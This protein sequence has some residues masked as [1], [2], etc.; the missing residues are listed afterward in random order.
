M[1]H[2]NAS[3]VSLQASSVAPVSFLSVRA[4]PD[5]ARRVRL[6]PPRPRCAALCC[7][8]RQI[9]VPPGGAAAAAGYRRITLAAVDG[10]RVDGRQP[11]A[12]VLAEAG[13]PQQTMVKIIN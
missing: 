7:A 9:R 2:R 4:V 8:G 11:E 3:R 10:V 13:R 6:P 12:R 5:L 1:P